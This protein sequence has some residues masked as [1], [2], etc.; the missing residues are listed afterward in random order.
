[1]NDWTL[2]A[3]CYSYKPSGETNPITQ[4]DRDYANR[5]FETEFSLDAPP[6]QYIRFHVLETWGGGNMVHVSEL[7]FWGKEEQ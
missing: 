5:G 7:T 1:M 4:E 2:L 3:E 6:M